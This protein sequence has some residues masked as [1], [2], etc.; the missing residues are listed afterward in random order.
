MKIYL[1]HKC[2]EKIIRY[3]YN[4]VSF[5][6]ERKMVKANLCASKG[7]SSCRCMCIYFRTQPSFYVNIYVYIGALYDM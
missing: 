2:K 3:K 6:R 7:R 5:D 1:I 4:L